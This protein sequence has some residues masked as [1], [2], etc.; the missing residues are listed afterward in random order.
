MEPVMGLPTAGWRDSW[1]KCAQRKINSYYPSGLVD[2]IQNG[3]A[4]GGRWCPMAVAADG[5]PT[6]SPAG[7]ADGDDPREIDRVATN[8]R[9]WLGGSYH[10]FVINIRCLEASPEVMLPSDSTRATSCCCHGHSSA[11]RQKRGYHYLCVSVEREEYLF[12]RSSAV[13]EVL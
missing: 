4:C 6:S 13:V 1:R 10:Q 12:K 11:K 7:S 5:K 8:F 3:A 9:L 2:S